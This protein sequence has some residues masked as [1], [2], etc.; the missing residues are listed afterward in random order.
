VTAGGAGLASAHLPVL[1]AQVMEGLRVLPD[2][3][4][5]DGTFGRGG[6]AR[7]VLE[8]L[9]PGGRLLLMDK[10]PEAI[11]VAGREFAGDVGIPIP[12]DQMTRTG[13]G[14]QRDAIPVDELTGG[15][16]QPVTVHR[17]GAQIGDQHV[18]TAGICGDHVGMWPVLPRFVRPAAAMLQHMTRLGQT[19]V[20]VDGM[21]SDGAA[22]VVGGEQVAAGR[23][24][25][26]VARH[27]ASGV[28][29]G[30]DLRQCA[31]VDRPGGNAAL[32]HCAGGVEPATIGRHGQVHR[33]RSRFGAGP[34]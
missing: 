7:G 18:L 13:S 20:V 5:L 3:T 2:G 19:S 10:D 8:K 26:D 34:Q 29:R 32:L 23:M 4:Y 24:H 25:A 30:P 6:H 28:P 33:V 16:V 22:G 14:R 17:V 1:F 11:A 12:D 27:A 15:H 31:S 21:D 9:G